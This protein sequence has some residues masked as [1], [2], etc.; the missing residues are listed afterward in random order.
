M[1]KTA[2]KVALIGRDGA[3]LPVYFMSWLQSVLLFKRVSIFA[4]GS[5]LITAIVS[6]EVCDDG[7]I[8]VIYSFT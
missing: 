6:A 1:E 8:F 7:W 3:S 4:I 5:E 2:V